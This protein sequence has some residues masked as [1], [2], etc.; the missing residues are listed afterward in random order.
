M[1]GTYTI[2]LACRKPLRVRFGRLGYAKLGKGFYVY[3]GSALGKGAASL[4][5]RIGRHQRHSKKLRWH[6]DYLASKPSCRV[7]TAVFLESRKHLECVINR[8]L[9]NRLRASPILP[10][11]GASDCRCAGHLL[12]VAPSLTESEII[13]QLRIV[14]SSLGRAVFRDAVAFDG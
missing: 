5:A 4:E 1:K 3:T 11:I 6:V 7:T 2:I 12:I 13:A 8:R 9:T 14:Y 10:H